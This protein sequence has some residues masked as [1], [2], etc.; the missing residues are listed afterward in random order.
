MIPFQARDHV[1]ALFVKGRTAKDWQEIDLS[2]GIVIR[3]VLEEADARGQ[4]PLM[5][6]FGSC[7]G[8]PVVAYTPKA[9]TLVQ[10]LRTMSKLG[11]EWS[12]KYEVTQGSVVTNFCWQE[13][14]GRETGRSLRVLSETD[15]SLVGGMRLRLG[16][17]LVDG[18][19]ATRVARLRRQLV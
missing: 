8:G 7:E 11:W 18:S 15:P 3:R 17:L 12:L 6:Q 14:I 1:G 16:N 2:S 9:E 13:R 5:V 19:L 10:F 4:P